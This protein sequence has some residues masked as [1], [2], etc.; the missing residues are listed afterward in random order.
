V[1]LTVRTAALDEGSLKVTGEGLAATEGAASG[2]SAAGKVVVLV[3]EVLADLTFALRLFIT[4]FFL[5]S[6]QLL[7]P[8]FVPGQRAESMFFG[9]IAQE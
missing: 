3:L 5:L 7:P 8:F 4:I 2:A 6:P 9:D 1:S